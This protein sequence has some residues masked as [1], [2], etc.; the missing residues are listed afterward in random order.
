M[1]AIKNAIMESYE[2]AEEYYTYDGKKAKTDYNGMCKD[3]LTAFENEKVKH[4]CRYRA[5]RVSKYSLFCDWMAGLPSVFP[6]SDDIFLGSAVDWLA[7][8]LDETEEEKGRYTDDKAEAIACN[9]LYRELTKHAEK[10]NNQKLARLAFPGF[11]SLACFYP[12]NWGKFKKRGTKKW[13]ENI[14]YTPPAVC[15]L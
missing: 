12:E 6:V 3:I 4:D 1:E 5:G 15:S 9:L 7:D 11:D 2:A 14:F 8:I 10:A 13:K